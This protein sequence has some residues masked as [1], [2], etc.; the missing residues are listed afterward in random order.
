MLTEEDMPISFRLKLGMS[1]Y[2]DDHQLSEF[3]LLSPIKML[4]SAF[5]RKTLI[6]RRRVR[7]ASFLHEKW[8]KK[9]KK[10]PKARTFWRIWKITRII[11]EDLLL[12]VKSK[13]LLCW[14]MS[15]LWDWRS[16]THCLFLEGS[17]EWRNALGN[18]SSLHDMNQSLPPRS[19]STRALK[20]R[21]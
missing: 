4:L 17:V 8:S 1:L 2:P 10:A 6:F 18:V 16:K 20:K 12:R 19:P 3:N 5:L 15:N 9:R 11:N 14:D 13:C 7:N 21:K